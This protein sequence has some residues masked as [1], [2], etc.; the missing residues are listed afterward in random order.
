MKYLINDLQQVVCN[1]AGAI[2][3][4]NAALTHISDAFGYDV[5][6]ELF[7]EYFNYR[8]YVG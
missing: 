2:D 8:T 6:W 5:Y 3:K 4:S 7:D 1:E